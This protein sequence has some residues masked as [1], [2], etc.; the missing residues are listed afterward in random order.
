[1]RLVKFSDWQ[2]KKHACS[3]VIVNVRKTKQGTCRR[4][5]SF[6]SIY[7]LYKKCWCKKHIQFFLERRK[8]KRALIFIMKRLCS[9]ISQHHQQT[10]CTPVQTFCLKERGKTDIRRDEKPLHHHH[11]DGKVRCTVENLMQATY[12]SFLEYYWP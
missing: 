1:M 4:R 5:R 10:I 9:L 6:S 2:K 8:V 11:R 3:T 7:T 12:Y